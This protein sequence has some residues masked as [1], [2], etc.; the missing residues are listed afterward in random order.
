MALEKK[1]IPV[2]TVCTDEFASLGRAEAEV[3]GIPTLPIVTPSHPMGGLSEKEVWAKA[4]KAVDD[5]IYVLT[6]PR[7]K[8]GK[9]FRGK[10]PE[11]KGTFKPKPIFA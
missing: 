4:E 3:L 5:I 7:E 10:A 11:Q 9:E 2:A 8:L 6:T 1:G